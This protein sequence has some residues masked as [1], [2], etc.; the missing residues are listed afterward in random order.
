MRQ[1]ERKK[2]E[3]GSIIIVAWVVNNVTLTHA[4][5]DY[6]QAVIP[7]RTWGKRGMKPAKWLHGQI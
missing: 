5:M 4:A 2:V 6:S 1:K 7:V 3:D